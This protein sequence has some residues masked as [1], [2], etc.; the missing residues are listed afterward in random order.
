MTVTVTPPSL[1]TPW[2]RAVLALRLLQIDPIGL[3]GIWVKARSGPVRDQYM[4][5]LMTLPQPIHRLHPNM[6]DEQLFGGMDLSATLDSGQI[7]RTHGLVQRTGTWVLTMAERC[8]AGGVPSNT[9]ANRPAKPAG[10]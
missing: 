1:T 9:L 7:V 8:P 4:A 2:D 3:G 6:T 5:G 10:H